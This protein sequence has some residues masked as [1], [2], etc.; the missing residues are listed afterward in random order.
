MLRR[1][2]GLLFHVSVILRSTLTGPPH[3]AVDDEESHP[4]E[5][6]SELNNSERTWKL[7]QKQIILHISAHPT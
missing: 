5:Y 6:D 2:H 7:F 4:Y 3:I 1:R